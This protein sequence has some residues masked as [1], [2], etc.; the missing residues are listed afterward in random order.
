[1]KAVYTRNEEYDY[2]NLE[3]SIDVKQM[4]TGNRETEPH[5]HTSS[6][7]ILIACK[8]AGT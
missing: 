6:R 2:C 1:M 7:L 5:R 8:E 4:N 3:L